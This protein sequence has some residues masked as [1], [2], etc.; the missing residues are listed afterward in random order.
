M[1]VRTAAGSKL[2]IGPV[3]GSSVD[4]R[5]E[6][7]AL[8]YVEVGEIESIGDFGDQAAATNFTAL[9]DRRVRKIKTTFDAG[10][11]ALTLG[12]DPTDTGQAALVAA[13]AEDDDYAIKIELNDASQGS[14]SSP[15]TFYFR[16]QVQS[17]TTNIG[18]AENVVKASTNI[19]INSAIIEVAA[20]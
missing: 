11:I 1:T 16:G 4:T 20:V 15:T 5:G 7:E 12:R 9:G 14:P 13:L 3:A 6:F 2:Y 8:S 10:T 19:A 18:N 17:Y